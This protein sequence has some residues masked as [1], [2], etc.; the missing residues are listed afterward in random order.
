MNA[1]TEFSPAATLFGLPGEVPHEQVLMHTDAAS[2]LRSILAVHST[3]RGPAF[4]GCRLWTYVDDQAA[5]TDALR[6]SHG[7]SLKNALAELPFGGGKA[8]I[9]RP[10]TPFDRQALFSAL[11]Q[12]VATLNGRY[13][14][15]EDVGSTTDDMRLVRQQTPFVSGIPRDGAFGGDPSPKTAYSV[16]VAIDE[17]V[18]CR[19]KR[20]LNGVTVAVQGLGAV[21]AALCAYLHNAGA[22][23]VVADVNLARARDVAARFGA[24]V[25]DPTRSFSSPRTCS[26]PA[27][28]APCST[29]KRC[30]GCRPRSSPARRTTSWRRWRTAIACTD[31]VCSIYRIFWLMPAV[32]SASRASTWGPVRRMRSWRKWL[33]SADAWPNCRNAALAGQRRVPPTPG[34]R[35]CWCA[36]ERYPGAQTMCDTRVLSRRLPTAGAPSAQTVR[37]PIDQAL[38]FDRETV[39]VVA[40]AAWIGTRMVVLYRVVISAGVPGTE[41]G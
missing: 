32:S 20:S 22:R 23:L 12:A 11:G 3:A 33:A 1:R 37:Q 41:V 9:L 30:R 5:L 16:F 31:A 4:G 14:T 35:N 26:P 38:S 13:I 29:Q 19:L 17:G 36:P 21:G 27:R 10:E 28:W 18:Q 24:R 2:G 6:L 39:V 8:V 40:P 34:Q 25:V 15:A 7:M